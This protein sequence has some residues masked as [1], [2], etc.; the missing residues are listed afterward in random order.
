MSLVVLLLAAG[1]SS[2]MR[3][4]D[5]LLEPVAGQPLLRLM[6]LRA[7]ELAPV[8]VTLPAL[9]HPRRRALE[10]LPVTVVPVPEAGEGMAASIRAGVAALGPA[11]AVMILPADMP[12]L[13]AGDLRRVAAGFDGRQIRR[14]A[15]GATPGHPVL[16]PAE[17]FPELSRLSGDQGARPVLRA[18]A[19][20]VV[21]VALPGRHALTDLDTPEDWSAWRAEGG[22]GSAPGRGG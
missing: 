2:R 14:G 3:G 21:P 12:E 20:R 18:H 17:L 22:D 6:A 15:S 7:L 1:A 10:G 5:K 9:D 13:T 19:A 11:E 8:I 16:F 4:G